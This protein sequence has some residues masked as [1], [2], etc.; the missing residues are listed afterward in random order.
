M[1]NLISREYAIRSMQNV[2]RTN[3]KRHQVLAA[4]EDSIIEW[5]KALPDENDYGYWRLTKSGEKV[6]SRCAGDMPLNKW[7]RDWESAYCPT[8]GAKMV[9]KE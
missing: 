8:C 1:D 6:C 4:N 5:L 3:E 9:V 2:K 7:K